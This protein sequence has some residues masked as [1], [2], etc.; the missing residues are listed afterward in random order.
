[1]AASLMYTLWQKSGVIGKLIIGGV[2][3]ADPSVGEG[4]GHALQV[5]AQ[6]E[7]MW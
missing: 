7:P 5:K 4:H 3:E 2:P 1:M 6:D